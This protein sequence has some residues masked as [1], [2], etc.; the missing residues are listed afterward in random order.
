MWSNRR[1]ARFRVFWRI[2]NPLINHAGRL[3]PWWVIIE[4]T[5][6]K[7]GQPRQFPLATGPFDGNA[8][9]LI[10]VH[11]RRTLWLRNVEAEPTVRLR[12]RGRWR[13]GRAVVEPYDPAIVKRFSL[14]A[15]SATR[16]AAMDPLLVRV[17]LD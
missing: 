10:A 2:V 9:W 1:R 17:D 6:R 12:V 8:T 16:L 15:R 5:G 14:Y 7:T 13:T 3:T 4:T 11:G